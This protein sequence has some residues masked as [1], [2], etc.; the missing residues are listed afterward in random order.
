[1]PHV[2]GLPLLYEKRPDPHYENV[3]I[4]YKALKVDSNVRTEPVERHAG[5]RE[6][7]FVAT[8]LGVF[9]FLAEWFRV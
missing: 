2:S 6:T 3:L 8:G 4:L 1:M 5:V 9:F 7:Q